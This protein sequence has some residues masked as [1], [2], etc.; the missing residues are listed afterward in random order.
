MIIAC[1]NAKFE[2]SIFKPYINTRIN[3]NMNMI[4]NVVT[5]SVNTKLM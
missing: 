2:E 4:T 3:M 1:M 5:N